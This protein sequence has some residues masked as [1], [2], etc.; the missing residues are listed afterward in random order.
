MLLESDG[1]N[2]AYLLHNNYAVRFIEALMHDRN[3]LAFDH[4]AH[5]FNDTSVAALCAWILWLAQSKG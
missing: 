1:R 5:W 2:D 3:T 4:P